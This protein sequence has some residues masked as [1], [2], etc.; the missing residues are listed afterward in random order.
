MF[1][2]L[3][4]LFD[5]S[6]SYRRVDRNFI[7]HVLSFYWNGLKKYLEHVNYG[8]V[9]QNESDPNTFDPM[10]YSFYEKTIVIDEKVIDE[11]F[12]KVMYSFQMRGMDEFSRILSYNVEQLYSLLHEIDH[13]LQYKKGIENV[14]TFEGLLMYI[15]FYPEIEL[16]GKPNLKNLLLLGINRSKLV[17]MLKSLNELKGKFSRAV[18][19]ERLADIN[20]L[21]QTVGLLEVFDAEIKKIPEVLSFYK[22]VLFNKYQV[23]YDK[24]QENSAP[25][26]RYVEEVKKLNYAELNKVIKELEGKYAEITTVDDRAKFGLNVTSQDFADLKRRVLK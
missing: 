23:G 15:C 11:N 10:A 7:E 18:P 14:D 1:D 24:N 13:S 21:K 5:Y 3:E 19:Y 6:A 22:R 8:D 12:P 2:L 26:L 9:E 17:P 4:L 16:I 20:S 25:L